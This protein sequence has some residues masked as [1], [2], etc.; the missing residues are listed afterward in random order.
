MDLY[1]FREAAKDLHFTKTAER[2]FI[3]QQNLSNHIKRLEEAYEV[4]LFTRKPKVSLTYAGERMLLYANRM[5]TQEADIRN[6]MNDIRGNRRGELVVGAS[7]PRLHVILP[8]ILPVFT[9]EFPDIKI[10]TMD[11]YAYELEQAVL[12]NVADIAFAP[13]ISP[14]ANLILEEMHLDNIY[15]VCSDRLLYRF[16]GPESLK[17]KASCVGGCTVERLSRLPFIVPGSNNRL[18]V[19]FTRCFETLGITPNILMET[20]FPLFYFP[21]FSDGTAAGFLTLTS[22]Y[23]GLSTVKQ[24]V[25]YFPVLHEEKPLYHTIYAIQNRHRYQPSDVKRFKELAKNYFMEI[26]RMRVSFIGE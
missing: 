10:R 6:E 1:Y 14:N 3:S 19:A 23:E 7:T 8:E 17:L 20:A 22:L 24:P 25:N 18:S 16:Y 12:D 2:L 13:I 21:L 15:I 4:T 9:K 26:E 11:A 5:L